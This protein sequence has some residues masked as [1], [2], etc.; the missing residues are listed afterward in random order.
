MI[1]KDLLTASTAMNTLPIIT[2]G[3]DISKFANMPHFEQVQKEWGQETWLE[4]ND[5]YCAKFLWIKPGYKCSLHCHKQKT[6]TFIVLDGTVTMKLQL[7][8]P[9]SWDYE[10]TMLTGHFLTLYP[11]VYHQFSSATDQPALILEISTTHSDS[12][13]ERLEPSGPLTNA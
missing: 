12:D 7:S 6:E 5:L 3:L 11:E 13:V 10:Y 2:A 1:A 9:S 4:N 8:K